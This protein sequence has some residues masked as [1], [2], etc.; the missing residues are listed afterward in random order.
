MDLYAFR[1]E[2][3]FDK[4]KRLYGRGAAANDEAL[5]HHAALADVLR[6]ATADP[7]SNDAARIQPLMERADKMLEEMKQRGAATDD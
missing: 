4:L 3:H 6:A 7:T 2:H 1:A 5:R